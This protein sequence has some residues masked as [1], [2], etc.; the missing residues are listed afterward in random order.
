MQY[1]EILNKINTLEQKH[2]EKEQEL[3]LINEEIETLCKESEKAFREYSIK[4]NINFLHKFIKLYEEVKSIS[5]E[6]FKNYPCD[7]CNFNEVCSYNDSSDN[8]ENLCVLDTVREVF[9]QWET[10]ED[11]EDEIKIIKES[12]NG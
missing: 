11:Y 1:K 4:Q 8:V 3:D 10:A 7:N 2:Q 5:D 9:K 12:I 6:F